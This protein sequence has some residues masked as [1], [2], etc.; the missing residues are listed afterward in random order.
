MAFDPTLAAVRFG[1]GL[2]PRHDLPQD[3]GAVLADVQRPFGFDIPGFDEARPTIRD[4]QIAGSARRKAE[5]TD[6]EAR[7]KQAYRD[8]RTA[9]NIAHN[10]ALQATMARH[11]AGPLGFKARLASFW[12]DHFTVKLRN[13]T[14][15][16]LV[17][18]FVEDAIVPHL[19]GNFRDML[20]AVVI[21]PMMLLYLQQAQS[22]GPNSVVG[23]RRR[24]GI[25]ENL[26]RELLELHTLGAGGPYTQ[27]DVRQ[28]AELLTGLTYTT[29][30]GF[31]FHKRMAEPG[32]ETVLGVTYDRVDSLANIL[33]AI[34][35]IADHPQTARHIAFK[36]AQ[37]FIADDPPA[38]MVD[39]MAAVYQRSGGDLLAVYS[40]MLDHPTAWD[41]PLR[42]IKTPFR[43]ITS[44]LRALG[45]TSSEVVA[46]TDPMIRNTIVRPLRV[47]GQ[48]WERPAGPDGWPEISE[49]WISP[50][51]MAGRI[52][53]A[54]Q[55]PRRLLQ[56]GVPDPRDFVQTALGALATQDVIFAAS[57][58]EIRE[59]GVGLVLSAPAFQRS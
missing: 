25:N 6:D 51:G 7:A 43:F 26:A 11:I 22:A 53:W 2:S 47:M 40:A 21:H 41:M 42:K 32:A 39:A 34:D 9:A 1:S 48:P 3:V 5:G 28:L 56:G 14:Q 29:K 59:E 10:D 35:D 49:T 15:T 27:S 54:M 8:V 13:S 16:H 19:D 31:F 33:T 36:L 12:A 38:A 30:Q 20:R 55:A 18:P 37:D 50:Q 57:S 24:R 23:Q 46:L 4:F 52:T 58:A 44:G 45:M 17:T